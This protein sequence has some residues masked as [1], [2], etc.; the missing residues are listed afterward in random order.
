MSSNARSSTRG[1][2]RSTS[3]TRSNS[4]HPRSA[5]KEATTLISVER[6]HIQDVLCECDWRINGTGNAAEQLGLHPNTLRF[7]MRKLGIIRAR[8]APA[9]GSLPTPKYGVGEN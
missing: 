5:Q 1:E 9:S 3:P 6:K 2:K 8:Q 7:R 4:T